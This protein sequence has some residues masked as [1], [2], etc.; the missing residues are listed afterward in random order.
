M[1]KKY[2]MLYKGPFLITWCFTD[3]KVNIQYCLTKIR[4]SIRWINPYKYD[5]KVQDNNPKICVTMSTY[6][7]RLYTS[8]LY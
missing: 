3:G 6:D 5:T 7:H 8:V 2:K 4:Y 1:H